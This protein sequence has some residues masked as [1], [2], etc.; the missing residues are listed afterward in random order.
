MGFVKYNAYFPPFSAKSDYLWARIT[1]PVAE[2]TPEKLH[3]TWEEI[4]YRSDICRARSRSHIE[5]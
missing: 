5:M 3:R 4:H 2:I 1:G